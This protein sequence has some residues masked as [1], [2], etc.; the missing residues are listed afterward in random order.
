[1]ALAG[2]V[3]FT[4]RIGGENHAA[5]MDTLGPASIPKPSSAIEA[6]EATLNVAH[7]SR[8]QRIPDRADTGRKC[9]RKAIGGVQLENEAR[10]HFSL[11]NRD[12]I[13]LKNREKRLSFSK[14]E[15]IFAFPEDIF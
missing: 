15:D 13:A 14:D 4:G 2:I 3:C 9:K 10:K 8:S 1:M 5:T 11:F 7:Y 12:E 6:G